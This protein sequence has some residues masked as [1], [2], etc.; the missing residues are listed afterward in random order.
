MATKT[1]ESYAASEAA[2]VVVSLG[3]YGA[4]AAV[5]ALSYSDA[6]AKRIASLAGVNKLV[7][8]MREAG[9]KAVGRNSKKNGCPI[10]IEFHA[11]LVVGGIKATTANNYL[12]TFKKAVETGKDIKEWNASRANEKAKALKANKQPRD[13]PARDALVKLLNTAGGVEL[14]HA[15]GV[16]FEEGTD[17]DESLV[18]V[19]IDYLKAEGEDIAE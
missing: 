15:L 12:T 9:V 14:V 19:V 8:E 18:D 5:F 3:A 11:A 17:A 2:R 13:N 7:A 16:A 4:R 1:K 10:A 6:E